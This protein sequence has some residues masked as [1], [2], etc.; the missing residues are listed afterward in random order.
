MEEIRFEML[1]LLLE[2]GRRLSRRQDCPSPNQLD[3]YSAEDYQ[4][5]GNNQQHKS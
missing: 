2:I 3:D 1:A 4:R 5:R